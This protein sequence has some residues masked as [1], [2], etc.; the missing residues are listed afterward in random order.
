MCVLPWCGGNTASH[1]IKLQHS[2][3]M[4]VLPWCEF[5][6]SSVNV[7]CVCCHDV[8]MCVLP[9]CGCCCCM[10]LARG[11]HHAWQTPCHAANPEKKRCRARHTAAYCVCCHGVCVAGVRCQ[12]ETNTM[13]CSKFKTK[14]GKKKK[15]DQD[16]RE[17][18]V[19]VATMWVLLRIR[20]IGFE[21]GLFSPHMM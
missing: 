14:N 9:W 15:V 10:T 19:C 16:T 20:S 12:S 8:I 17:S 2:A 13:I 4:C 21:G 3:I 7:I 5:S 6:F 1:C 18:N 11:K